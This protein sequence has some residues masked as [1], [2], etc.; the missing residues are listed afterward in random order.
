MLVKLPNVPQ[1]SLRYVSTD[2]AFIFVHEGTDGKWCVSDASDE[3]YLAYGF[4]TRDAAEVWADKVAELV[5]RASRVGHEPACPSL[6]GHLP[7][8]EQID[9]ACRAANPDYAKE[10]HAFQTDYRADAVHWFKAWTKVLG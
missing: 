7:N 2:L 6:A 9:A 10:S 5:N 3:Y 8:G 1:T 4:D